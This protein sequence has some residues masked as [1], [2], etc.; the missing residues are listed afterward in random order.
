MITIIG[1]SIFDIDMSQEINWNQSIFGNEMWLCYN[2]KC[3]TC[4]EWESLQFEMFV[5]KFIKLMKI[6]CF[7]FSFFFFW[8][9]FYLF[10]FDHFFHDQFWFLMNFVYY[11]LGNTINLCSIENCLISY[12]F[13]FNYF[14]NNYY[15]I[16]QSC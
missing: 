14:Q 4:M 3:K 13:S 12:F 2:L 7:F 10:F 11:F 1:R 9:F 6:W 5:T 16:D 15:K 8:T